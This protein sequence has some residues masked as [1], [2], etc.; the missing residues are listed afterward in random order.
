MNPDDYESHSQRQENAAEQAEQLFRETR[1]YFRLTSEVQKEISEKLLEDPER[2]SQLKKLNK[3]SEM[4]CMDVIDK[5]IEDFLSV[6]PLATTLNLNI[7]MSLLA[8]HSVLTGN[9][10]LQNI[11]IHLNEETMREN[12]K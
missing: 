9:P 1:G 8:Q 12:S 5:A 7:F 3:Q 10:T 11:I 2:V 6:M 4:V